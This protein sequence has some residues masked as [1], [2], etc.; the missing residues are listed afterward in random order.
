LTPPPLDTAAWDWKL[1]YGIFKDLLL[2]AVLLY[3]WL[4]NKAK[5]VGALEGRIAKVENDLGPCQQHR[6]QTSDMERTLI[7]L[8]AE[9]KHMPTQQSI[10]EL[11]N[12]IGRL[13]GR[14]DGINR[15]ADLMNR[16]LINQGGKS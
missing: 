1:T 16:F 9:V 6:R 3:T 14:L 12:S 2:L 5:R 8:K 10:D 7:D 11:N 4:G 13:E 15:V